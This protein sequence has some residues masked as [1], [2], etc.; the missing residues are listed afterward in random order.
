MLR[1]D[2]VTWVSGHDNDPVVVSVQGFLIDVVSVSEER[3]QLV[4]GLD[5]EELAGTLK[6]IASGQTGPDNRSGE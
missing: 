5:P 4:F 3:G 6:Q 2:L 1:N